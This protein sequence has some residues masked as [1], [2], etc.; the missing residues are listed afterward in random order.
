[1]A[2]FCGPGRAAPQKLP[3]LTGVQEFSNNPVES[4]RRH[5]MVL[6]DEQVKVLLQIKRYYSSARL[7]STLWFRIKKVSRNSSEKPGQ[8]ELR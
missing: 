1:M 3:A 5:L 2:E 6:S 8:G 4:C 7:S